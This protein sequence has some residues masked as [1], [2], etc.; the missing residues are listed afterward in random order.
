MI[1]SACGGG[2]SATAPPSD[3][4][5]TDGGGGKGGAGKAGAAGGLI[6]PDG[7]VAGNAGASGQGGSAASA[8]AGGAGVDAHT[9]DVSF[10]YDAP[11]FDA[12]LNQDSAC[13]QATAEAKP[14]PLDMYLML[15]V[16]GSMGS[17]CNVG[18]TTASKWCR[19]INAV[20]GFVQ[21]PSSNG[22]GVALQ[23][24]STAISS[25]CNGNV[26]DTPAVPMALLPGNANAII[27]S[28]NSHSPG[29]NTP[30]E[31]A[32]RG[33]AKYTVG[34]QTPGRVMIGILVTDGSPTSCNTSI[35]ALANIASQHF[36]ATGI[37]TYVIGMTGANFGNL[38]TI[39]TAGGAPQHANYC[40]GAANCHYY[41]VGDGDPQA[42]IDALK[43]IQQ[44][45]IAC[46]WQMPTSDAGLVDPD[47]I[48]I[49]YTPGGGG[50]PQELTRVT[51]ASQC[52]AGGW[53]YDNNAN[54]T[55]IQ[56]CPDT[57]TTVQADTAAKISVLLGCQGT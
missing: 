41:N 5:L 35:P 26:Y 4:F 19:A 3:G 10:N 11:V 53:Y 31:G 46:T 22:M 2:D 16:T 13:A 51:D 39:A 48:K 28:L 25:A 57:C 23:F 36:A 24:F 14:M 20:A 56:L 37:R 42:F 30:T 6:N 45:A 52:V 32:L 49:Q 27:A 17:D 50:N 7:S 47:K 34:A 33:I 38:E 29:G 21:A 43:Q 1:G 18:G 55:S 9:N 54:P 44:S 12:E 40:S 8:G 15:D